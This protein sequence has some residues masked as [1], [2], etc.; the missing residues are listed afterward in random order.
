MNEEIEEIE[1][2]AECIKALSHPVRIRI[3]QELREGRKCVSEL[4]ERIGVSQTSLSQHLSLLRSSGWVRKRKRALYVY[5]YLSDGGIVSVLKKIH[6]I[7]YR[8]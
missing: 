8:L 3:L 6:E 7:I 1:Q 4:C 2:L 5:Y